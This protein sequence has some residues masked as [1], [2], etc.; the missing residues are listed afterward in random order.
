M[1]ES[2][3]GSLPAVISRHPAQS[4][5]A[6]LITDSTIHFPA[7]LLQLFVQSLMVSLS[8]IDPACNSQEQ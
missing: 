6:R 7:R 5:P 8:M 2:R 3:S 4:F 1:I